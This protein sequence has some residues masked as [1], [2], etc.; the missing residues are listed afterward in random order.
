MAGGAADAIRM[1]YTRGTTAIRVQWPLS[2]ARIAAW[3]TELLIRMV[4]LAAGR[5][6]GHAGGLDTALARVVA[7]FGA[8]RPCTR[9]ISATAAATASSSCTTAS[10]CGPRAACC[11]RQ[12]RHGGLAS[13]AGLRA[14]VDALAVRSAVTSSARPG[15]IRMT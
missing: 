7:V 8:A 6:A 11:T 10:V 3:C 5:A 14:A 1:S 9:L 12:L 4:M 15:V 2:A 13:T